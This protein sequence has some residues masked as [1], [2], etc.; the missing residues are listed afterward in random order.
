[1]LLINSL[2][3]G[4]NQMTTSLSHLISDLKI[5]MGENI[6][7]QDTAKRALFRAIVIINKDLETDYKIENTDNDEIQPNLND[8]HKEMLLL[9]AQIYLFRMN[10]NQKPESISFKSN[11]KQVK[12]VS[13]KWK[14]VIYT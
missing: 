10:M 2:I 9:Q 7:D 1:M 11:D 6:L 13:A 8:L 14:D 4:E 3:F 5:D 12:K